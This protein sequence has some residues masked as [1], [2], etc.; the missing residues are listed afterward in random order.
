[1][2]KTFTQNDLM[3]YLYHETSEKEAEAIQKALQVD[4]DLQRRYFQLSEGKSEIDQ[5]RLEPSSKTVLAI[6]SYAR[7][8]VK[9]KHE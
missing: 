8:A 9:A 4:L 6:M 2:T 5:V 7:N 3:R 1:M